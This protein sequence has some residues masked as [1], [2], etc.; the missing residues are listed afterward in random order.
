MMSEDPREVST[1]NHASQQSSVPVIVAATSVPGER[2]VTST[3]VDASA[4]PSAMS[5]PP[6]ASR[7]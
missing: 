7:Q 1:S 6:Q 3:A 5:N 2:R 4:M